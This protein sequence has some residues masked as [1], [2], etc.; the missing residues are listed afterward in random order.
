ML[1]FSEEGFA[2]F[3]LIAVLILSMWGSG[4]VGQSCTEIRFAPGASSGDVHGKIGFNEYHC[5]RFRS[6]AGQTAR[7]KLSAGPFACFSVR[8]IVD[9]QDDY[10]FN[11]QAR[12][13]EVIVS[14]FDRRAA[15]GPYLLELS[16]R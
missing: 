5:Y 6:G 1:S 8:D 14:T 9:C 16:I 11:T 10:I 3:R 15:Y 13:Y 12:A 4:A 7:L 2:M